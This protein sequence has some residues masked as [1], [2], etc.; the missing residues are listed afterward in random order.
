MAPNTQKKFPE[1]FTS[2]GSGQFPEPASYKVPLAARSNPGPSGFRA[3]LEYTSFQSSP[4]NPGLVWPEL[5]T[6]T[7]SRWKELPGKKEK[8]NEK[9]KKR[10]CSKALRVFW[11]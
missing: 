2:S 9:G 8:E 1:I 6:W 5:T 4:Q 3:S 10:K 7:R 11:A